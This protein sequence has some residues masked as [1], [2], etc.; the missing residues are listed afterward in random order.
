MFNQPP[1]GGCVLKLPFQTTLVSRYQPAAFGR[2]CV[3]TVYIIGTAAGPAP[4]PAA[5][6]R[7]CVET[8]S[9]CFTLT[10]PSPAAFGRLCVETRSF[11][12]SF[13]RS[14]P[15]AFGRLCVET[16]HESRYKTRMHP[17]PP[18]GGC[19]LKLTPLLS[20]PNTINP[21]AFGRLCVETV[22]GFCP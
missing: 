2:L 9:L 8:V 1:S 21:A 12:V 20:E 15:A 5:F 14:E 13:W 4:Y 11:F 3:E 19:V 17:Q 16:K 7:L 10:I 6:G 22:F 18:S